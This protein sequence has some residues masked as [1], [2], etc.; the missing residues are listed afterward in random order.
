VTGVAWAYPM[1]G[2]GWDRDRSRIGSRN[3]L[4]HL[5][6]DVTRRTDGRIVEAARGN[7]P[8][9][10]PRH[11]TLWGEPLLVTCWCGHDYVTVEHAELLAGRTLP[12]GR[13][14]CRQRAHEQAHPVGT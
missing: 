6:E 8:E 4:A 2:G 11:R 9:D 12:C 10:V 3:R 14:R 13:P 7:L 5:G 1:V